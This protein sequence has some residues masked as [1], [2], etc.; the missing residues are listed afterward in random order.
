MEALE[1]SIKEASTVTGI[2]LLKMRLKKDLLLCSIT[3]G[4]QVIIPSGQDELQVGDSVVVVTTHT[5]LNDIRDIL[6][7]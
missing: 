1:F 4:N 2:P 5:K 7:V 3:R 6:E